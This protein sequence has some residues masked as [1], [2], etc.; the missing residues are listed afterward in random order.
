MLQA[1]SLF[2]ISRSL[3]TLSLLAL[4]DLIAI[5]TLLLLGGICWFVLGRYTITTD[6]MKL[7]LLLGL[8]YLI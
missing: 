8:Y 4:V 6:L 7:Q 3:S 2:L 5:V 1:A